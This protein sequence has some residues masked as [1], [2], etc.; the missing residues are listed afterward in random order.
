[1]TAR[2]IVSV[3]FPHL[4]I[5]R[6]QKLAHARLAERLADPSPQ[7][8]TV[9]AAEGRHGP[10]VHDV[11]PLAAA[12]GISRGSRIVDM[13]ALVPELC[14]EDA[15]PQRDAA[16]LERLA[17]W[18]RRWCP[19]VQTDGMD[20]LLLDTTGSD[21]LHDG[22][23]AMLADMQR[24]FAALGLTVRLAIAPAAGAAWALAR[25]GEIRARATPAN[26]EMM[27]APLPAAALRLST[28][29]VLLL[30]RLGLK[31]I[32][33]IA[34]VPREA[35]VRRFR[36]VEAAHNNP[37]I[38]LDQAMGRLAEPLI[39]TGTP[40]PLLARV[41]L[42]EP[43]GD[44]AGL[45][46][47]LEDLGPSLAAL[48]RKADKGVRAL[49]FTAYR[50]DGEALAVEAATG[51]ATRD[52]AHMTALFGEKL[53]QIDPGF[54]VEAATLEAVRHEPLGGI[55]DDFTG[56]GEAALDEA[57]L[58]D[59]LV[60]R[61]GAGAVCRAVAEGSHL[62]ERGSA[63]RATSLEG[64]PL[65]P[66]QRD[67]LPL[68]LLGHPEMAEVI[69]AVPEGAPRTIRWRRCLH[70]IVRSD[71]PERIAPEWWR[72]H[73]ATR[74]R[75]YYRVEDTDGRRLWLFR[76]GLAGDGRGGHPLWFVHGLDG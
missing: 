18:A 69:H 45:T 28:D 30:K 76:E 43:V 47:M 15:Q 53:A 70:R 7:G 10:V 32:G 19:W 12:Q 4:P 9:L 56:K 60:Q 17:L 38:R 6:W 24:A 3:Y 51:L 74:L 49:R 66:V 67:W 2:R 44:L 42:F 72:S 22:E 34:T 39:P 64:V 46:R 40:P 50:V 73:S 13:R 20:G 58:V 11:C 14:V 55:Q 59:R 31:R 1:M 27:L 48:L 26:L 25:Y 33:D 35:L 52:P 21:H 5:Q 37:V 54:G 23:G 71:G 61:L 63:L 36:R 8:P 57:R 41:K 16:D 65:H 75:D 29:T 68:R 62:P